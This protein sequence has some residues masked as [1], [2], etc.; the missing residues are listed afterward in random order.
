MKRAPFWGKLRLLLLV[1]CGIILA[2]LIYR[3]YRRSI[4]LESVLS[5]AELEF[6]EC[7]IEFSKLDVQAL[8]DADGV[9]RSVTHKA[10]TIG[11]NKA[12]EFARELTSQIRKSIKEILP[13][14]FFNFGP[15]HT[16][17]FKSGN[18]TWKFQFGY[19]QS[20]NTTCIEYRSKNPP[21]EG[22]IFLTREA[23]PQLEALIENFVIEEA[24]KN[25]E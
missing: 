5:F 19:K 9:K 10:A 2:V 13:G 6:S 4:R 23:G 12:K 25:Q 20:G 8:A 17:V 11:G 15:T 21:I 18:R 3:Q 7:H 24:E 16:M 22:T 14:D 1:C